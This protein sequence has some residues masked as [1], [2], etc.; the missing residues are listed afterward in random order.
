MGR[1]RPA[2]LASLG[3][4]GSVAGGA[5]ISVWHIL[6]TNG[7]IQATF[8]GIPGVYLLFGNDFYSLARLVSIPELDRLNRR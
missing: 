2:F 3:K 1:V 8:S 6:L 5:G 4:S 7:E